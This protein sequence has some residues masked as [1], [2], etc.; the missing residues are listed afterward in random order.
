MI[1][2]FQ[3]NFGAVNGGALALAVGLAVVVYLDA[4]LF[5]RRHGWPKGFPRLGPIPWAVFVLL[6]WSVAVPWYV[7]RRVRLTHSPEVREKAL[8]EREAQELFRAQRAKA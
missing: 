8:R 3:V 6:L 4:L 5:G 7:I 1:Q 2:N